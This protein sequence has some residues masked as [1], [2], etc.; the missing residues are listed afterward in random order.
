MRAFEKKEAG[1]I[2]PVEMKQK[3]ARVLYWCMFAF[4]IAVSAISLIPALWIMISGFKDLEEF[5]AIPPTIIPKTFHIEK[6]AE[7]WKRFDFVVYYSN[8]VI[9][10]FGTIVF[11]IV[12][13]GLA[14]YVLSRLKPHGSRAVFLAL[15]VLMLI[16]NTIGMVPYYVTICDFPHL[17]FSML[18]TY[19]A[20]WIPAASNV[21]NILL[22]K[23][24]F[25]SI[26][27]SYIE[28]ARLD[29]ATNIQIF[30]KI[31]VPL[32]IPIITTISILTFNGSWGDFFW[33]YMVLTNKKLHTISVF[34]FQNKTGNITIDNYMIMLTLS[35]LPPTIIFAFLQKYIMSGVSMG[36]IK[37]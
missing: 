19:W 21:F 31:I 34:L 8:T 1:F 10:T 26:P 18:N 7:V 20:L 24:S 3:S 22:F 14:G 37:G 2:T 15:M 6:I 30:C 29:G 4:L 16:P 25:D 32:S 36:G 13:N 17:H 28:A 12:F 35:I 33:P 5:L 9:V 23:N 27:N 11:T